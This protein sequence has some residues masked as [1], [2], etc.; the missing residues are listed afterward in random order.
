M[1]GGMIATAAALGVALC[2]GATG[3]VSRLRPPPAP[4]E[5]IGAQTALPLVPGQLVGG[6]TLS[7]SHNPVVWRY[8]DGSDD[9]VVS[10]QVMA[11]LGVALGVSRAFDIGAVLPV[12]LSQQGGSTSLSGLPS[13]RLSMSGGGLGDLRLVPRLALLRPQAHRVGLAVAAEVTL[14]TGDSS[15]FRGEGMLSA[16]PRL[17]ATAPFR[18]AK[19]PLAVTVGAGYRIRRSTEV[20]S[21][22]LA[23]ELELHGG[24][25]LGLPSSLPVPVTALAELSAVTAAAQPFHEGLFAAEALA[26]LRAR[27]GAALV[28]VGGSA[29]LSRGL[30]TPDFRVL[31]SIGWAPVPSDR[32]GDGIPDA[33][34]ACPDEAEDIDGYQDEDGC[35]D[36]GAPGARVADSPP[37]DSDE[38]TDC[39]AIPSG[40]NTM[41]GPDGCPV[42][43]SDLDG[44]P[45]SVDKCPFEKETINGFEDEDGCPDEGGDSLT[46]YI[47][48]VRIDIKATINFETG[49]STIKGE[50]HAVL[51]QVALQ[52][53][54]HPEVRKVRVE[55]HTDSV[56]NEDDNLY[57]SQDR[58]DSVRRYLILRGVAKDRVIATGF[59]ETRPIANNATAEG[60]RRNRRVE[61]VIVP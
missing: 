13:E 55:G 16:T 19:L 1:L 22:E 47:A 31:V 45:D 46:E 59:G 2:V 23:N 28:T 33:L 20:S 41:L 60:R 54:Q 34:D 43:D 40:A 10:S 21:L 38:E 4:G 57:L 36:G 61:F 39:P 5:L 26:G 53:L 48:H 52:I 17:L 11:D 7:Y 25:T 58:A 12:A 6:A 44:I 56:G 32:D 30:G 29:G 3:D 42:L 8:P 27:L 9:A 18:L 35:P 15:R 51:N 24:V 49:R 37:K 50:S 14:P